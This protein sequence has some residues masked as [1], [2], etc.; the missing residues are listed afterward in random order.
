MESPADVVAVLDPDVSSVSDSVNRPD[1][2]NVLQTQRGGL[3]RALLRHGRDP[4]L[5]LAAVALIVGR[6]VSSH[7]VAH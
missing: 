7:S 5:P 1:P 3:S 4:T 6:P 2:A